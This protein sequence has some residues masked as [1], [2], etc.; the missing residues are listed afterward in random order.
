V[1]KVGLYQAMI[2]KGLRKADL[3]RLLGVH[4]PQVDRLLS[5]T[6]KSKLEQ[7][8]EAL[9]RLGYRVL[10]SVEPVGRRAA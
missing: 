3:M 5:L 6:H 9:A 1:A 8:E 2:S 4:G 10:V 7:V